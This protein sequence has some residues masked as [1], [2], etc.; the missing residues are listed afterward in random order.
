MK[1]SPSLTVV[2]FSKFTG[3]S[4]VRSASTPA[5]PIHPV[6]PQARHTPVPRVTY[7]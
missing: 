2:D 6:T 7:M 3:I 4:Q 5:I 1:Y